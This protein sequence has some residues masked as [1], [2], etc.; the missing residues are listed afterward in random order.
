MGFFSGGSFQDQA[1]ADAQRAELER[2]QRI[3][4][5]TIQI[6]QQFDNAFDTPYYQR[7]EKNARAVY[8]PQI[9]NQ[10]QQALKDMQFAL[11]RSG[12]TSSSAA[13]D[14]GSK[15][16]YQKGLATQ[17]KRSKIMSLINQRKGDVANAENVTLSQL[18]NTADPYAAQ[19]QASNLIKA[20]TAEP[21]YSP[22][23][24]VFTDLTAG[25]A[26][27]ADLERQGTNRYNIGVTNWFNP[28]RAV[29][30]VGG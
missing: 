25:L 1:A 9:D 3:A 17:D 13:S 27:Q 28:R 29:S 26:T 16:E 8:E 15:L 2:Q 10:Y 6:R 19:A 24:Q 30:N 4:Q 23:G 20:N 18:A 7:L 14:L 5:G 21:G 22:L 12:L 11:S